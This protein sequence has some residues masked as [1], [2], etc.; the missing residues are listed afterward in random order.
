MLMSGFC[1]NF[2]QKRKRMKTLH[3][4]QGSSECG[5]LKVAIGERPY[6]ILYYPLPL[7]YSAL[8]RSLSMPELQRVCTEYQKYEPGLD[9]SKDL[10]K[11]FS[12]DLD[13]FDR[14]VV[15]WSNKYI[16]DHHLLLFLVCG[17]FPQCELYQ[18][19]Y[20]EVELDQDSHI[21]Y[22]NSIQHIS[23]EERAKYAKLYNNLLQNDTHLRIYA[24]ETHQQIVSVPENY[25]DEELLSLCKTAIPF[26]DVVAPLMRK[27]YLDLGFLQGR[28]LW[29]HEN[30]KLLVSDIKWF[31]DLWSDKNVNRD[32]NLLTIKAL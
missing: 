2:A 14:V 16:P 3:L 19:Q 27:Y 29:L 15:W 32:R 11:F 17:L 26:F 24:D 18:A 28:T 22:P 8:P 7:S 31:K 9:F 12:L 6:H 21:D 1:S 10:L 30:G 20:D 25:Y 4:I 13:L 5:A 23:P